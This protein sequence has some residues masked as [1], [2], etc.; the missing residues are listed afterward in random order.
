M[1]PDEQTI[2]KA[3]ARFCEWMRGN[4]HHAADHFGLAISGQPVFGWRLRTIGAPA[5]GPG[6]PR[7]LRVVTEFPEWAQGDT[8][9]ANMDA[10]TITGITKPQVLDVL[11]W[12][13]QSW[14]H[15]R[16]EVMTLLPGRAISPTNQLREAVELPDSWWAELRASIDVLRA[17]P[18]ERVSTDQDRV[19]ER[20]RDALGAEVCAQEWETVHGDLHWGNLLA[21]QFALLDWEMWGRGPAGTDAAT[22]LLY[23][24]LV[25]EIA[26][27][28]HAT[29]ADLFDTETGRVA[30][31]AVAARLHSR[32]ASGDYSELAE[33]LQ[34]H[35][36]G[37]G[38]TL[39]RH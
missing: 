15:Q 3:D 14:R 27:R 16:A 32:I 11:E 5:S 28:V 21:P 9:T 22:L 35:V 17:T 36:C 1:E 25:P 10:N 4:L 38:A 29:F 19:S 30:Q 7:W 31:L 33:P 23:S 20:I 39:S 2:A 8:W 24:L 13:E 6:G 26:E 12:D 37:L 18:T 34:H